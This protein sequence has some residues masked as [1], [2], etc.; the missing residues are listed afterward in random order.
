MAYFAAWYCKLVSF[1]IILICFNDKHNGFFSV[2]SFTVY[3][4]LL[5]FSYFPTAANEQAA[6]HIHR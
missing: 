2:N 6:L 5:F 4:T 3:S 1:Y